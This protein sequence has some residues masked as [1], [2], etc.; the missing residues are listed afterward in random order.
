MNASSA[1]AE[2][3]A[4][5]GMT[6]DGPDLLPREPVFRTGDL[7]QGRAHMCRVLGEHGVAYLS[8]ER[9]LDLRHREAKVG[10][11][12]VNS[13]QYGAAVM[14]DAPLLPDFYLLQFTLAGECQVWQQTHHSVLPAGSVAIINPGQAFKKAW[15]PGTSQLLLRINARLVEREFRAWTG[16]GEAGGIEFDMPSIDNMAR[17][18]T[19][20]GYVR[21]LC[22]D[23]GSEA[24]SLSHSL[25][26]D[27]VASGLVS[28]L[29][30]SMPHNKMR[31][32]GDAADRAIAPFFVRRVEK[33]IEEH[34]R[35]DIALEDLTGLAG[36]SARALQTGFR[37]FRNTT[38][39]AYLRAI[40]LELA[41]A[42]LAKA[43]W[44]GASVAAVAN[45][46]GFGHLG[47]FARAYQARFGELPSET[48]YHGTVGKVC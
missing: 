43:G 19:L 48:L 31:A 22:N 4:S 14:I 23:L 41:R 32:I 38:P 36:V 26:A 3:T 27:R 46:H 33:F 2:A 8:R 30:T 28:I 34:A 42:D 9:C 24:S 18:G 47:R 17:V 16:G 15:L 29:L 45:A 10:S 11:I 12:A 20:S 25:V 37:R 44:Q 40:R 1:A 6:I 7:E 39:M 13:L 21:M 35:D 5:G